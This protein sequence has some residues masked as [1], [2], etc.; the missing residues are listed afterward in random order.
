[1]KT[2]RLSPY[3]DYFDKMD[4]GRNSTFHTYTLLVDGNDF[5]AENLT[6]ENSAGP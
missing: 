5:H 2:A 6:I 3:D 1:M 4:R